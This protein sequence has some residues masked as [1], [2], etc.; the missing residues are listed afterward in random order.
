MFSESSSE[1]DKND[2]MN[3]LNILKKVGQHPNVVC[4]VGACHIQGPSLFI[5]KVLF[6]EDFYRTEHHDV[7]LKESDML[8]CIYLSSVTF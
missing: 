8:L 6:L 4:L 1:R 5:Q 7:T 2:F 3:E